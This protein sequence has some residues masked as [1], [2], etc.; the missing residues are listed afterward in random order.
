MDK[1]DEKAQE[2]TTWLGS[3]TSGD[4]WLAD[5]TFGQLDSLIAAALREAVAG[6]REGC[7]KV[8]EDICGN[9]FVN[10]TAKIIA[11]RIRARAEQEDAG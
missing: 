7:A 2:I 1:W 9:E 8:S 3:N 10:T 6:E 5:T 11:N 4:E